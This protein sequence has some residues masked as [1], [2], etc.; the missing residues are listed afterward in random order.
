MGFGIV[1]AVQCAFLVFYQDVLSSS[2]AYRAERASEA[3]QRSR[4]AEWAQRSLQM[5]PR[6]GY[7]AFFLG[8]TERDARTTEAARLFE[9]ALATMSHRAQPLSELAACEEKLGN[10][11]SATSHLAE[12]LAVQPLPPGGGTSWARLGRL[13]FTQERWSDGIA[14][15]RSAIADSSQSY[16]LFDGLR[17]GYQRLAVRD[18]AVAATF[19]LMESPPQVPRACEQ[20]R[21][22][23]QFPDQ[24]PAVRA[25][26]LELEDS[27]RPDDPKRIAITNLRISLGIPR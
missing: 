23:W 17:A 11:T 4:V 6:Q 19:A 14:C 25:A 26:L 27:L 9:R 3:K 15:F 22:L 21:S 10:L 16:F 24:R 8:T 5:N 12:A 2:F 1:V 7:A 18:M 13:L 20:I